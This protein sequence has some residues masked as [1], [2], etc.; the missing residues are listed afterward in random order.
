MKGCRVETMELSDA[1]R[2]TPATRE[3]TPRPV[4]DDTLAAILDDARFAP[5]GGNRQGWR[6]IV[7]KDPEKR[8]ALQE[9]YLD[10]WYE[11]LG[12]VSEGLTPFN[13]LNDPGREA[14]AR[15]KA[16]EIRATSAQGPGGFAENLASTPALLLVVADL[17]A[18]ATVDRDLERYTFAGG[19]SIYPFVW[20]ILLAARNRGLG[21]VIT[22][23]PVRNEPQVQELFDLPDH[24]V[25]A[26]LVAL[27]EPQKSITKLR[28]ANVEEFTS[29]DSFVGPAF[30]GPRSNV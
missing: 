15:A 21:G 11:Y 6:V 13:V 16:D 24:V 26:A 7:I 29:L 14:A 23:M 18:L 25:V 12:Q 8:R 19:A 28:R 20:N 4:D 5:S 1:L 30:E 3:F 2:T 17:S 22:T 9:L 10:G 27:G